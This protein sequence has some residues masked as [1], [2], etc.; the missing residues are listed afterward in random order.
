MPHTS[1]EHPEFV[2]A[3]QA[4]F[5]SGS[6]VVIG[7]TSGGI[8]KAYPAAHVG[9]HGVVHDTTTAFEARVKR[10]TLRF[11]PL[12]D[13]ASKLADLETGSTWDAYGLCL[14]G[15]LAG[16][17][18]K[19]LIVIAEFWFAWSEFHLKTNIFNPGATK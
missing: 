14:A 2:P 11:R 12:D 13:Q 16:L 19:P 9:Q 17:R 7:V 18:L 1:V 10:R 4:T 15:S 5:L 3:T 8:A 6:D